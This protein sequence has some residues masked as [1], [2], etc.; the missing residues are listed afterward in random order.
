MKGVLKGP[1]LTPSKTLLK[2]FKKPFGDPFKDPFRNPSETLLGSGGSVASMR[3]L[4]F[5][6]GLQLVGLYE[7]DRNHESDKENSDSH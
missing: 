4:T 2:P 7:K 6:D 3:V 1:R 5:V